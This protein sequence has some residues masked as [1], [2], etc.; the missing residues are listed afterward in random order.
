MFTHPTSSMT[1]IR[2]A[3]SAS[4]SITA[5]G[6]KIA[7]TSQAFL[8]QPDLRQP[9]HALD[10]FVVLAGG[11]GREPAAVAAHHFVD[12]QDPGARVVLGH[13][14]L[15]EPGTHLGSG[16]GAERL[17]DR[18]DVVVDRLRQADDGEAVVVVGE[19]GRKVGGGGVGV[20]AADGVEHVDTVGDEPVSGDLQRI[21][22]LLQRARA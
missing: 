8:A 17:P 3:A 12:D 4:M 15:R 2:R 14:V 13:D 20:V 22:A 10:P 11:G 18:D 19:V 5:S 16:V 21:V 7:C 9:L 6:T 1:L